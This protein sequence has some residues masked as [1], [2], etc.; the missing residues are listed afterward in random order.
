MAAVKIADS[1]FVQKHNANWVSG[2]NN[3]AQAGAYVPGDGVIEER[4]VHPLRWSSLISL[5]LAMF[6]IT[7]GYGY[8]LPVLPPMIAQIVGTSDRES[9]SRHTGMLTGTYTLAL[10]LFAPLWGRAADRHGRRSVILAGLLGFASTLALFSI[11][12]TLALLYLSRLLNGLFASAITPAVYALIGDH[13]P[14]KEWRAHRFAMVNI[15]G[16]SGFLIGPM[17]GG[18]T[19]L[20]AREVTPGPS[21]GIPLQAP[22][23]ITAALALVIALAIWKL[24][25]ERVPRAIDRQAALNPPSNG[26]VLWR[27]LAVSFVTAL[28]VGAFEVGLSLLGTQTLGMNISQLGLMFME[29]SLVMLVVQTLVFSPFIKIEFTRWFFAPA[30]AILASSLAVVPLAETGVAMAISVAVV[31]ASAGVLSP[32]ATYWISLGAGEMQGTRLG[33]QT[34]VASLGQAIGSAAGGLFFDAKVFVNASFTLT[35][36]VVLVGLL[37]S[38]GLPRLLVPSHQ[39]G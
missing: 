29:C 13:A 14:S 3:P 31:A 4:I 21:T 5:L 35:S 33:W 24:V 27:L 38:I 22:S 16:A 11:A 1:R 39:L 18:L 23:Y 28:A 26:T 32:I 12:D 15:A 37:A 25:P 19:S 30:L 36:V 8:L 34:A 9:L 2:N 17:L 20:I 10:F 6:V 7:V